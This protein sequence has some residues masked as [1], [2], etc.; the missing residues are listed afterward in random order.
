MSVTIFG[1]LHHRARNF[2]LSLEEILFVTRA[3]VFR[4]RSLYYDT[5]LRKTVL[6]TKIAIFFFASLLHVFL[7]GRT[8]FL[9]KHAGPPLGRRRF[10]GLCFCLCILYSLAHLQIYSHEALYLPT[11]RI[12]YHCCG[13]STFR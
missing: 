11:G 8:D 5:P 12:C 10:C 3:I 2:A 13:I 1:R 9:E 7:S 6:V 4:S